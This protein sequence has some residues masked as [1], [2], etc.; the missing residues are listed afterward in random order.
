MSS[1]LLPGPPLTTPLTLRVAAGAG[2][3][4]CR[5]PE[6]CVARRVVGWSVGD[7]SSTSGTT[8]GP[9]PVRSRTDGGVPLNR[10]GPQ[11]RSRGRDLD[12]PNPVP[13]L[14]T[15]GEHRSQKDSQARRDLGSLPRNSGSVGV[16]GVLPGP[17]TS[18]ATGVSTWTTPWCIPWSWVP[19]PDIPR[20]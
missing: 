8:S 19:S 16:P 6:D 3:G 9:Y 14:L 20:R 10:S 15:L 12:H 18:R 4:S 13:D 5:D 1:L 11:G 17:P 2:Q 7:T